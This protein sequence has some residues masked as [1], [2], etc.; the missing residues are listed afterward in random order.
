MAAPK[1]SLYEI[2]GIAPDANELDIG[3]AY[4]KRRQELERA[5]H[6][7]SN[8]LALVQEAYEIL[9][10]P[11]RRKAY[12]AARV[13][14]AE[15]AAAKAQA[16]APDLVV[17]GGDEE[18]PRRAWLL[19][20]IIAGVVV[21]GIAFFMMR[22]GP[23]PEKAPP[24]A[25]APKAAPPPPPQ[26][27]RAE[28]ILPTAIRATGQL[29]S[30]DMSGAAVPLGLA[31]SLEPGTVVTTCHGINAGSKLVFRQGAETL[32]AELTVIDEVL[33]LCRIAVP[34]LAAK[35]L[36]VATDEA[37]AGD[38][39]FTLGMNAKR[40]FAL[41]E[42][43]VKQTRMAQSA[44][45]LEVSMPIAPSGSGAPVLD[46]YGR[47]VGI[48]TTPHRYGSGINAAISSAWISEMRSRARPQ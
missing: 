17:E 34:G 41:T 16:T 46:S 24:V 38:K 30:Y 32:S 15:R 22:S 37:K 12:D 44:K 1:Q 29:L 11:A 6:H 18:A 5:P 19:P 4:E 28:Q 7:D 20:A 25:E 33:D 2:L 9:S 48:A 47:V 36:A 39:I 8:A 21:L 14:A 27:M 40:D 43:T 10:T 23:A 26:P 45:V 31:V 42:G 3:L 35:T 13:T